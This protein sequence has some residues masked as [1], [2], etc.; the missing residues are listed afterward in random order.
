MH[1][2]VFYGKNAHYKT[3]KVFPQ[4]S[5]K[6]P[7]LRPPRPRIGGVL[8]TAAAAIAAATFKLKPCQNI[9]ISFKLKFLRILF[10]LLQSWKKKKLLHK[11][12]NFFILLCSS[13]WGLK[14]PTYGRTLSILEWFLDPFW[15]PLFQ[16]AITPS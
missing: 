1:S 9:W 2:D 10:F 5:M 16:Y 3:M 7:C 14:K 11:F 12:N 15:S 8:A 13:L 6:F 4:V